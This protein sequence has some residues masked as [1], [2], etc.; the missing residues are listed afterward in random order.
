MRLT[1]EVSLSSQPETIFALINDVERVA[2]CL[3]GATLDGRS[4]DGS[5]RGRVKVK[6]GPISAAYSGTVRFLET[7]EQAK[8]LVLEA[9]GT[10]E[11]GSGTAEA[12]VDVRVR[13]EGEG[14]V[15]ALDTD[16]VIRGKVAQFGGGAISQVSQRL[17]EQFAQNLSGLLVGG[18][19]GASAARPAE[20]PPRQEAQPSGGS[21]L[22]AL[23]L[24]PA[25]VK[26]YAPAAAALVVGIL[27]GRGLR[28]G[29]REVLVDERETATV[30]VGASRYR[31][32]VRHVVRTVRR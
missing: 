24:V 27:V 25:V 21:E 29:G 22:D 4:D 5:Y 3:P 14:S 30:H 7:D 20:T 23:S 12:K 10:D 17:M 18:D 1:N 19:S 8:R 6:V 2:P 28:P 13:P 16:L 15:L 31:I 32:P 9:R 11:H 26:R